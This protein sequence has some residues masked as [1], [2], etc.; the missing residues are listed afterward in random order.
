MVHFVTSLVNKDQLQSEVYQS[1]LTQLCSAK[2]SDSCF[3]VAAEN[4]VHRHIAGEVQ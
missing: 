1:G 2:E 4:L 3:V